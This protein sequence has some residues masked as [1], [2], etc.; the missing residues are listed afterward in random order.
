[1]YLHS[2]G[3]NNE[4]FPCYNIQVHYGEIRF[5]GTDNK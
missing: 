4:D 5:E 1:M 3:L 2:T